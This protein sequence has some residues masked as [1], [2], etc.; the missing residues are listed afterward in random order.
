MVLA[1]NKAP[2]ELKGSE[3][4]MMGL[5]SYATVTAKAKATQVVSIISSIREKHLQRGDSDQRAFS[6]TLIQQFR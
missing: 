6:L 1:S 4:Y 3:G 5:Y 2:H